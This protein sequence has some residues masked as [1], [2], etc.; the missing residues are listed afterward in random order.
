MVGKLG[1]QNLG[2]LAGGLDVL[3]NTMGVH[4]S[5]DQCFALGAGPL[6]MEV[7]RSRR[8]GELDGHEC[9]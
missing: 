6:A 1:E 5:L 8:N 4:A 7:V 2:Q 3:V 9:G